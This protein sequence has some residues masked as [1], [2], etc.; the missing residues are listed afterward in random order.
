MWRSDPR[1][2]LFD[3]TKPEIEQ[4]VPAV[5]KVWE[6]PLDVSVKISAS[7]NMH[8]ICEAIFQMIPSDDGFDAIVTWVER[9]A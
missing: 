8:L 1:F 9:G 7:T 2:L 4:W 5:S 3:F 6:A